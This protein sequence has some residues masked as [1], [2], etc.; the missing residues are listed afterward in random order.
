MPEQGW[1]QH[2]PTTAASPAVASAWA[3]VKARAF[4]A[5]FGLLAGCLQ[6]QPDLAYLPVSLQPPYSTLPEAPP[7]TPIEPGMPV[8]L[9]MR[10]QEA[11][12]AGVGKWMKD[13]HS[14]SFGTISGVKLRGGQVAVC[15][16]VEGRNSAGAQAGFARFVGVI[17][18]PANA[19][20]FVVVSIAQSGPARD[21]VELICQRSG[22]FLSAP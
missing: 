2:D 21:E 7:G 12:V 3:S 18:G 13:P 20:D 6:Q 17:L 19:P 22:I 9:N 15:G 14:A 8:P 16:E 5:F 4:L 10:Q 1:G 11:V